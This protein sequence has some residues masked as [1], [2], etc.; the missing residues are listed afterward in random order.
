M[1][2]THSIIPGIWTKLD[3]DIEKEDS[4]SEDDS[5]FPEEQTSIQR[6]ITPFQEGQIYYCSIGH[7]LKV[8]PP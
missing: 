1:I 8:Q 2:L 4:D 6:E 3:D 5:L 7:S